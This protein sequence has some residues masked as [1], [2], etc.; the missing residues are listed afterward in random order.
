MPSHAL[1]NAGRILSGWRVNRRLRLAGLWAMLIAGPLLA[2]AT[3]A[4]LG[5]ME[6]L[7]DGS[8]LRT[9]LFLDFFYVMLVAGLVAR[10]VAEMVAARRRRSAGSRLHMR[11]VRFFTLGALIPTVLVATTRGAR[12]KVSWWPSLPTPTISPWWRS[13]RT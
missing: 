12:R 1:N 5:G 11:L 6:T 8:T 13:G 7:G 2:I 10:R 3:F 4:A 9:V